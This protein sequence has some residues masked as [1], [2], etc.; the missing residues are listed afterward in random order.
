MVGRSH[1]HRYWAPSL[2]ALTLRCTGPPWLLQVTCWGCRCPAHCTPA[3]QAV[4]S[5][6]TEGS[7][8]P[9]AEPGRCRGAGGRLALLWADLEA[10]QWGRTLGCSP[11]RQEASGKHAG[12]GG[13]RWVCWWVLSLSHRTAVPA[14][15]G[16][17]TCPPWGRA[18]WLAGFWGPQFL[19]EMLVTLES[20]QVQ[21]LGKAVGGVA[22]PAPGSA[23]DALP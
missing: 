22:A 15:V 17:C 12:G 11:L 2:G 20:P 16:L 19:W 1:E 23:T 3:F 18:Q 14:C 6:G 10:V 4:Q 9:A 21:S 8:L 7:S 13:L 5:R